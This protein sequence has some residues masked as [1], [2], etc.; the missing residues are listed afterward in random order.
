MTEPRGVSRQTFLRGAVGALA[1]GA[2]FGSSRASAAPAGWGDLAAAIRGQ[3]ILPDNGGQFSSAKSVFNT[4]FNGLTP[5]AVVTPS[6]AVDVQKALEFAAAHNLK[7]APR[8]GGHSYVGASTAN[9]TMVLDLRQLPGDIN[10]NAATG[11]SR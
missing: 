10:Y 8:G 1:A 4:N 9:G 7:V 11:M 5:A 6:S 2:V 3:V